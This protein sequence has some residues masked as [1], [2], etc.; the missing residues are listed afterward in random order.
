MSIT[1]WVGETRRNQPFV[2]AS[3]AVVLLSSIPLTVRSAAASH[4]RRGMYPGDEGRAV[5]HRDGVR[6]DG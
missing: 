6:M 1:H 5:C 4:I 2:S 3:G